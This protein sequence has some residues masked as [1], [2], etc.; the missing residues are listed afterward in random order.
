MLN[1]YN[2]CFLETRLAEG[3]GGGGGGGGG[4]LIESV[5]LLDSL[6]YRNTYIVEVVT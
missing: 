1:I 2:Y 3:G 5:E 4:S 6:E